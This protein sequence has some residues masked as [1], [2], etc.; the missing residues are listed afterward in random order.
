[1][2]HEYMH[3]STLP[4]PIFPIEA[5][6]SPTARSALRTSTLLLKS[7]TLPLQ[8]SEQRLR[9][10]EDLQVSCLRL[11][12]RLIIVVPRGGLWRWTR[13]DTDGVSWGRCALARGEKLEEGSVR[14]LRAMESFR[15]VRRLESTV[16]SL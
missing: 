4:N 1:M 16:R 15:V 6:A 12:N 11:L 9:A 3:R 14:T 8:H 7:H 2:T 13:R 5:L 10:L